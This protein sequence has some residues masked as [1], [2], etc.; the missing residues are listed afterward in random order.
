MGKN[1]TD[2]VRRNEK[3]WAEIL[4][5]FG[6]SEQNAKDFCRREG[7]ALSS[8]QRWQRRLGSVAAGEFVELVQGPISSRPP[9]MTWDF[10][11]ALPNGVC[12]RFR[13]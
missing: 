10:E 3:Q 7:V 4:Q 8:F 6:T 9:A 12:L 13:G 11:V 5:R 1:G 2:R